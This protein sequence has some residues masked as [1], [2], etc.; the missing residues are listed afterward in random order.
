VKR[1]RRNPA[2]RVAECDVRGKV[3]GD[4]YDGQCE[5]VQDA[6][7]EK[8][9]YVALRR[10][11]GLLMRMADVGSFLTRRITRRTVLQVTLGA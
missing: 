9:A 8:R 3:L 1:I 4:W 2:V 5:I 6:D 10:K 7:Q 11:Y